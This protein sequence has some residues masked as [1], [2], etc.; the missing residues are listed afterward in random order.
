MIVE[1]SQAKRQ[2]EQRESATLVLRPDVRKC[3]LYQV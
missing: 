1:F 3:F 2:A